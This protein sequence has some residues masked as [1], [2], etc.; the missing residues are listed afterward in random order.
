MAEIDQDIASLLP[1]ELPG[2]VQRA[3]DPE[4]PIHP[5]EGAAH[6][7]SFYNEDLGGEVLVPRVRI[8][9]KGQ[10]VVV[11]DPYGEAMDLG[12]YILVPGPPGD[13]TASRATA[14]SKYISNVLI[15]GSR[16]SFVDK[17]LYEEAF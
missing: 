8:N 7:E 13:E 17:P 9:D 6:T 10:P 16:G 12:D 14:L 3:M 1:E 2:W 5:V 11:E 15:G 4:S